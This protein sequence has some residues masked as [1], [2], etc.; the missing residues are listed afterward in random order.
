MMQTLNQKALP[1]AVTSFDLIKSF[2]VVIMI[3][4]H[5]GVYFFPDELW[6]RAIGRIGFPVWF[7]LAGYST[8]KAIP[9]PLLIG[10]LIL[11]AV[12]FVVGMPL[13]PLNALFTIMAIRLCIHPFMRWALQNPLYLWGA[14]AALFALI[15]PSYYVTEYGT[16]AFITAIFGYLVRHRERINNENLIMQYMAFALVGFVAVQQILFGFNSL[17]LAVMALGTFAIRS[18][19]F[20]LRPTAYPDLTAR[21]PR[22]ATALLQFGGRRTLE[23]YVV[24]L[25]M[26]KVLALTLGYPDFALFDLKLL[27]PE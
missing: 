5:L 9:K 13:L 26:F 12:N 18:M 15:I 24:H 20:L 21:L 16:Q 2:A 8:G 1:A 19:L 10:A 27:A 3:I 23:I 25:L 7:F 17:Q 14:S 4:D 6:W 22:G 11:T